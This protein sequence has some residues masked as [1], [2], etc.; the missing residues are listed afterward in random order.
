M[1]PQGTMGR[2]RGALTTTI[3]LGAAAGGGA[4]VA[5]VVTANYVNDQLFSY[6]ID[7]MPDIDQRRDG[8]AGDGGWHCVPTS[9]MN[10]V[11]YAANHG[12]GEVPP[13]PG[14]WQA[15]EN[16]E[17]AT[18]AVGFLGIL[19]GTSYDPGDPA[20]DPP[21]GPSGGTGGSG[22]T[23]GLIA[24]LSPYDQFV[25][26]HHATSPGYTTN[27]VNIAKSVIGGNLGTMSYGRYDVIGFQEGIPLV[28][29]S[30]GHATT[31]VRAMRNGDFR[32]LWVRDPAD[33]SDSITSQSDFRN[34]VYDIT[35]RL[36]ILMD[37]EDPPG[38]V[39]LRTMSILD[40]D[41]ADDRW[42]IIDGH[43]TIRLTSGYSW[44]SSQSWVSTLAAGEFAGSLPRPLELPSPGGLVRD[45]EPFPA[46]AGFL[47]LGGIDDPAIFLVDAVGGEASRVPL[48]ATPKLMEACA[49]GTFHVIDAADV[50]RRL[51]ADL[52]V[53]STV[54][55]PFPTGAFG[56]IAT[57]APLDFARPARVHVLSEPARK[58]MSFPLDLGGTPEALDVPTVIPSD[59]IE[60]A[61][62][63]RD[64]R[65]WFLTG[66]SNLLV[67][68]LPSTGGPGGEPFEIL[69]FSWGETAS[70]I[71]FDD[72][73]RMHVCSDGE[74]VV[75]E[76][77]AEGT[78]VLAEDAAFQGLECDG[79][80]EL[81]RS[82][83]NFERGFHDHPRWSLNLA[84]EDL[85]EFQGVGVLDCVADLNGDDRVDTRDLLELL[86][87]WT[88]AGD[89]LECEAGCPADLDGDGLVGVT[90]LLELLEA[91]GECP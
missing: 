68:V 28:Q 75:L 65:V 67:G 63:P 41:P 7:H 82:T 81:D 20:A 61:V 30:G 23:A 25:V 59:V 39:G 91:W 49:T 76:R 77:D 66:S 1:S 89:P 71:A 90:D 11:M 58:L 6:R 18:I 46:A 2:H 47:V 19:M 13:G 87:A 38:P 51:G 36:V 29:R 60:I 10:M 86:L 57:D 37:N 14:S 26:N 31:I 50:L 12:F 34:Q 27:F 8:L 78:W 80:I 88:T 45:F 24:W 43:R 64:G 62:E 79:R 44:S 32:Q 73:G 48:P 72:A 84:P 15:D 69:S 55:L 54:Q 56:A 74:L 52:E 17:T 35:D 22:G 33:V 16:H 5:D 70:G 42:A 53:R 40:Y 85:V 3:V 4:A 21:I 9:A 83:S